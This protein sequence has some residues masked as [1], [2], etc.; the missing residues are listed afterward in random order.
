MG[1]HKGW[2]VN[3]AQAQA[4]ELAPALLRSWLQWEDEGTRA[5]EEH[6]TRAGFLFPFFFSEE[7]SDLSRNIHLRERSREEN[8]GGSQD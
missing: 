5:G 8:D 4:G 7:R 2:G 1:F 3:G 6:G